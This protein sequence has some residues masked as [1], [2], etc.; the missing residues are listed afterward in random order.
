MKTE[1][2]IIDYP[3]IVGQLQEVCHMHNGTTGRKR[4]KETGKIN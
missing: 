4:E 2:N 3:R 1:K